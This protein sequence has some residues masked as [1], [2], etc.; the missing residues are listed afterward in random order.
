V[1]RLALMFDVDA[2]NPQGNIFSNCQLPGVFRHRSFEKFQRKK[3]FALQQQQ[4]NP[5]ALP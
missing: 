3:G 5:D 1:L 4:Q 2:K